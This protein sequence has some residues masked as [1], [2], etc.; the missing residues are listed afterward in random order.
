MEYKNN[1]VIG[2]PISVNALDELYKGYVP[3]SIL[4]DNKFRFTN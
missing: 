4:H 1:E 2:N 3:Y